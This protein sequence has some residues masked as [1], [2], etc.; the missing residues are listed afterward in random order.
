MRV[1]S[2]P[3]ITALAHRH[4]LRF[5]VPN[6]LPMLTAA[7]ATV[8]PSTIKTALQ[9]CAPAQCRPPTHAHGMSNGQDG[10]EDARQP[11]GLPPC[12]RQ[13]TTEHRAALP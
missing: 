8:R 10:Q 2:K 4:G 3:D 12:H 9:R 1:I 13:A 6:T 5:C 7:M 11:R